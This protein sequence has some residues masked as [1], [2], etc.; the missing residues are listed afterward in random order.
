MFS[1]RWIAEGYECPQGTYFTEEVSIVVDGDSLV[2][3]KVDSR[4]DRCVPSGSR[5]FYGEI[6][7]NI[8]RGS[9]FE[10]TVVLGSPDNPASSTAPSQLTIV[11]ANTFR[12]Q[13]ENE[14]VIFRRNE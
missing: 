14:G 6:P 2:A 12:T 13:W 10:V 7:H 5:T 1:G 3:T 4:G 8:S 11:D 9:S